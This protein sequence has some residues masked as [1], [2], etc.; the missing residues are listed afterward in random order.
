MTIYSAQ[1]ICDDP[2]ADAEDF[3]ERSREV[4]ATAIKELIER[5][6]LASWVP[7]TESRR[8]RFD[9]EDRLHVTLTYLVELGPS[10]NPEQSYKQDLEV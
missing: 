10:F 5:G 4:T 8:C 1:L 2:T 3:V 7:A 6:V 9:R